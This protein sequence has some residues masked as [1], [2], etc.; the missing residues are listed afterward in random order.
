VPLARLAFTFFDLHDLDAATRERRRA[1]HF[2][3]F[4]AAGDAAAFA[5][6]DMSRDC[7]H[8]QIP[9]PPPTSS[10][11]PRMTGADDPA[12]D[13][14]RDLVLQ[15]RSILPELISGSRRRRGRRPV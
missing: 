14:R 1:S 5:L 8:T 15:S 3:V 10:I 13:H 6:A 9:M 12:P 4:A 11:T 7:I 2:A